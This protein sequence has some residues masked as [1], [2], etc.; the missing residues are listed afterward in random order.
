[1][2]HCAERTDRPCR[3]AGH[4]TPPS[5]VVCR[6]PTEVLPGRERKFRSL[7][8]EASFGPPEAPLRACR[9][10]PQSLCESRDYRLARTSEVMVPLELIYPANF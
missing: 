7:V 3:S 6:C 4:G 5:G 1:M 2:V 10:S 8:G 9:V